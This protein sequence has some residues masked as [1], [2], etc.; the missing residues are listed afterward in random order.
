MLPT[1]CR[2]AY[3]RHPLLGFQSFR[4]CNQILFRVERVYFPVAAHKGHEISS[5]GE[6]LRNLNFKSRGDALQ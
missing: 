6:K 4:V 3:P 2:S 5:F 1:D